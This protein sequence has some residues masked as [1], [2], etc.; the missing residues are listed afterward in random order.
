MSD[1]IAQQRSRAPKPAGATPRIALTIAGSDSGGGAG[2][3]ADLKTF[4]HFGV[5]GT[6]ALTLITAQNTLGVREVQLL[7]PE[8]VAKQIE[9]VAGDFELCAAK[10]GALGSEELIEAVAAS[11]SEYAIPNLVVDPVMIS[12]HGDRLLAKGA[13]DALLRLLL[14]RAALVTPNLHEAAKLL[15]RPVESEDQMRDAARSVHDLGAAAVLVKGGQLPGEEAVDIFY[16]GAE[17]VRLAAPRIDT[18]HTHGTGCTYSAAITALLARG[19]TLVDAVRQAKDFISRAIASAPGL[20]HGHGP[21]DHW[22]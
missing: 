8:L 21:V 14:P 13:V 11:V 16:D 1:S 17:F 7:R 10:T 4:H 9:A 6:S 20:G 15:G 19:E 22:A 12:K 3:Q 2:I 18:P 5:Y